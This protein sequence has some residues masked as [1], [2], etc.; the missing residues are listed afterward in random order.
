MEVEH[1]RIGSLADGGSVGVAISLGLRSRGGPSAD[2]AAAESGS[3]RSTLDPNQSLRRPG[4]PAKLASWG[5]AAA[6]SKA[7]RCRARILPQQNRSWFFSSA[8]VRPAGILPRQN[9]RQSQR[10]VSPTDLRHRVDD[11]GSTSSPRR[12]T[13]RRPATQS[14]GARPPPLAVLAASGSQPR[15]RRAKPTNHPKKPARAP[16]SPEDALGLTNRSAQRGLRPQPKGSRTRRRRA[17][18]S[19]LE[20]C[21]VALRELCGSSRLEKRSPHPSPHEPTRAGPQA[22]AV[23]SRSKRPPD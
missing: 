16:S 10:T 4:P 15:S 20:L 7:R 9:R 5:S 19:A 14:L 22:R 8:Q 12:R 13:P 1:R 17:P 2:S 23:D 11:C 21:R 6:E 18:S 3:T